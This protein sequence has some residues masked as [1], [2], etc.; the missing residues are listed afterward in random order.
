MM[1]TAYALAKPALLIY[2]LVLGAV[3]NTLLVLVLRENIPLSQ[4]IYVYTCIT[5]FLS[6][7]L[8]S[9]F[10]NFQLQ[11]QEVPAWLNS[12]P[13]PDAWWVRQDTV[14]VLTFYFLLTLPF[15]L[16]LVSLHHLPWPVPLLVLPLHGLGFRLL[17]FM[18]RSHHIENSI[19]FVLGM[20]VW[21]LGLAYLCDHLLQ[22]IFR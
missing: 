18:Q 21:F 22:G 13:Q 16:I 6:I 19:L 2:C 10:R 15:S 4:K 9:F 12:L 17:R 1:Q 5:G 7:F 3:M 8:S 20:S 14:F 11:R